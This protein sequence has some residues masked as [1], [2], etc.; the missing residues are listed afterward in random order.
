MMATP[1]A[2]CASTSLNATVEAASIDE[3]ET[4]S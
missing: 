4:A 2:R 1:L 3:G